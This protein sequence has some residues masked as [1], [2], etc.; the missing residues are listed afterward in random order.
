MLAAALRSA[1]LI[2]GAFVLLMVLFVLRESWPALREIGLS[3]FFTDASWHPQGGAA[4]GTFGLVPMITASLALTAGAMAL[5]APLGLLCALFCSDYAP[6][7]LATAFR[8]LM[9]VLAGIP[10]VVYGFWGLVVLVPLINRWQPPGASL[11]AGILVLA[12]MILPTMALLAQTAIAT[13]PADYR[14]GAAA[15]GLTRVGTLWGV[16]LPAARSGLFT[17]ALLAVG[18]AIGETMAVLMVCGNVVRSPSSLFAPVRALTANIALEMAY[19]LADHRSA[20]FVSGLL[21]AAVVVAL[22]LAAER[23]SRRVVH[24]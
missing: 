11:L 13:V 21:L 5:A 6:L 4:A 19:A 24:D 15:L 18:R 22:V 17:A 16:V 23:L 7:G 14:R 12:L 3:R 9:E 10:S 20:L 8:R 1:A 2:C